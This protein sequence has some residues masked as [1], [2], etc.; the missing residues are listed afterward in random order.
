MPRKQ[1]QFVP[2]LPQHI[3]QRGNN[4]QPIFF[5][6]RD[7]I[8]FLDFLAEAANKYGLA[9]HAYVLMGNHVHLMASAGTPDSIV[10]TLQSLAG[11]YVRH[12][13]RA[14]GRVGT[15]WQGRYKA[16]LIDSETY[17]LTCHRYIELNPVRAG[18]VESPDQWQW[19]SY[20]YN[21]LGMPDKLVKPHGAYLAL[22][23]D[24]QSRRTN[25]RRLFDDP[26]DANAVEYLRAAIL[27]GRPLSQLAI[28]GQSRL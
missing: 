26:V 28:R 7:R 11:R 16:S 25:Y 5:A 15:L 17:L 12:V 27:G 3:V 4:R 24:G 14:Q 20:G 1:R 22:G 21:A 23:D 6:D 19:S 13:N 10:R 8:L 18:M 2:H 9:V